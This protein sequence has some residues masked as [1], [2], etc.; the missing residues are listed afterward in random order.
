MTDTATLQSRLTEA[1]TALHNLM[2]GT[3]EVKV[4]VNGD[5]VEYSMADVGR[6]RAYIAE[7]KGALGLSGGRTRARTFVA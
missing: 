2:T 5:V 7:L 1:E 4:G 3:K 6:L